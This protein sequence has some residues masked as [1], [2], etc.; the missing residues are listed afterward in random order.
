MRKRVIAAAEPAAAYIP[1][2]ADFQWKKDAG[3]ISIDENFVAQSF[4]RDVLI[5]FFR[6]TSAVIGLVLI[7]VITIFAMV[8]PGMNEF[9]YSD[10]YLSQKNFAPR[11]KALEKIGILW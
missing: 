4:W 8:G 7:I 9:S 1:V 10:Q 6:K 11:V 2:D 3:D 5:R